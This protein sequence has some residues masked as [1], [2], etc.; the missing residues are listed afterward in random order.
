MYREYGRLVF[1]V[2]HRVLNDSGLAEEATQQTFLKAWRASRSLDDAREMAPWLIAIARRAAIDILR[3]EQLRV[4]SSIE[5]V[6]ESE[7]ALMSA[8]MT[9]DIIDVWEVRG[10]LARLPGDEH[11]VVRMQHFDGLTHP[12]IAQ[13]LGVAVGT[14]KSRSFRAHR[15]LAAALGHLREENQT[16]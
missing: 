8:A 7:P 6:P 12:E 11:D 15:R 4:A 1:A 16:P 14:V 13:R 9:E 2:A 10:A 3:R 5:S